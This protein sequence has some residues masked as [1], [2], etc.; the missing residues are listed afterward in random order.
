MDLDALHD[1]LARCCVQ[2]RKGPVVQEREVAGVKVVQID[3]MPHRDEAADLLRI[4][5]HFIEVGVR[6][7]LLDEARAQLP[8]ILEGYPEP[9]RLAAGPSYI[10]VGAVIGDQGAAFMLFALGEAC[11]LWKVITPK[12]MGIDGP[13][14]DEL[15]GRGMVLCTGWR[16]AA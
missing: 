1:L 15:A 14:A 6:Q 16:K 10:E 12:T 9:A 2:L 11:G 4:D 3:A 5:C 7:W 13:A 8:A